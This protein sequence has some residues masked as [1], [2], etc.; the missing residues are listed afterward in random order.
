MAEWSTITDS[1]FYR[2]GQRVSRVGSSVPSHAHEDALR[3]SSQ[4]SVRGAAVAVVSRSRLVAV[5][6]LGDGGWGLH[7]IQYQ[8]RQGCAAGLR[9]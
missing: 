7:E 9:R 2:G 4:S 6:C 1:V 5:L 3:D 8:Q